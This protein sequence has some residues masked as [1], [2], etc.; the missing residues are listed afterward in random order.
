M[1]FGA[2]CIACR[3]KGTWQAQQQNSKFSAMIRIL[4]AHLPMALIKR[5]TSTTYFRR[6]FPGTT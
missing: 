3:G 1:I 4:D 6:S 2:D 5:I